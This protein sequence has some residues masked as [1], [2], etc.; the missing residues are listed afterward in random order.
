MPLPSFNDYA[1]EDAEDP[2]FSVGM[3]NN[4]GPG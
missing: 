4:T 2:I 3:D 1:A